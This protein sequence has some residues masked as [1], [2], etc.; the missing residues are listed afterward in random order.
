MGDAILIESEGQRVE[1]GGGLVV[2]VPSGQA[3]TLVEVIWNA[4]GPEGMAARFRFLA[5]DIARQGGGV[6]FE[7]AAADMAHLC[8]GFALPRLAGAGAPEGAQ[9]IISLMDREVPFGQSDPEAT[10]FFEAYRIE[11]GACIWEAF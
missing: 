10:Q 1:P 6:D 3:V 9:V 7:T 2:P 4:S 8:Q 5:P 11:G